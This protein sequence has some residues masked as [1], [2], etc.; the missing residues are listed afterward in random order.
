MVTIP[1]NI[2]VLTKKTAIK[3]KNG[4]LPEE[5]NNSFLFRIFYNSS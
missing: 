1:M 2:A 3:A 5:L 4:V